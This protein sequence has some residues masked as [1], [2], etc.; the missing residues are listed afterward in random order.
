MPTS[1]FLYVKVKV[2]GGGR[3]F[4]IWLPP[5]ALF[6]LRDAVASF[7]GWLG[8]VPGSVGVKVRKSSDAFQELIYVLTQ[9]E[10]DVRV[11]GD[12]VNA[13]VRTL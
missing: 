13:H 2:R 9:S 8:L 6:V 11:D 3:K 1:N 7:D 12:A 10:I 4:R 5:I